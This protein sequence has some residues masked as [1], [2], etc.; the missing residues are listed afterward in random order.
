MAK[1]VKELLCEKK[2]TKKIRN[3]CVSLDSEDEKKLRLIAKWECCGFATLIRSITKK[4]IKSHKE[5]L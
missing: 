5:L 1:S 3:I 2:M 4:Y